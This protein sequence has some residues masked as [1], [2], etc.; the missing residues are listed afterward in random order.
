MKTA[1][2]IQIAIVVLIAALVIAA[3]WRDRHPQ[4]VAVMGGQGGKLLLE[5]GFKAGQLAPAFSL[6]GTDGTTYAVGGP[7]DKALIVNFWASWCDPCK[8]EA[9]DLNA[10]SLKYKDVL[11]VYGVNVTSQDYQGNAERF[12]KK[13]ELSFPVMFDLKGEVFDK[14]RGAVFPTNVLIGKDG[15]IKEVILG[16]LS[17]EEL[18]SKI[19]ALTGS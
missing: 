10:L 19:I 11:E 4:T 1:R 7:R 9:P 13:Y 2:T 17:P 6:N 8:Q 16:V 5:A 15:V 14:Y 18:E 3:V 12:I